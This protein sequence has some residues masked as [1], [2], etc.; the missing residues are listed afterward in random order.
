MTTPPLLTGIVDTYS[1]DGAWDF[2]AA[3]AGGV[4]AVIH[5]A[6][7]GRTYCDPVFDHAMRCAAMTGML[8]GAYHFGRS[9]NVAAQVALFLSRAMFLGPDVLLCLDLEGDLDDPATMST[10]E[11]CS[12]LEQVR[13]IT[14]RWPVLYGGSSK[15]A[16]RMRRTD[17][18]TRAVFANCD[19]W[20]ANYSR[21]PEAPAPWARW[22]L[23]QYSDGKPGVGPRDEASFP[24]V[25]PG[26][27]RCDRSA[28]D[29]TRD[30]LAAWWSAS[31]R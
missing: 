24:R 21:R 11:A 6:T 29:G 4:V 9:G 5:K 28:F 2:D 31:G 27:H 16:E 15:T 1:G 10:S 26:F 8:R 13:G 19:L 23:W 14:G 22:A 25:T 3:R 12:F 30:E 18:A 17:D 20:L 7:E